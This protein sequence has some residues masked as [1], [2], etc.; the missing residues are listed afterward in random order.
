MERIIQKLDNLDDENIYDNWSIKEI[1]QLLEI[2]HI[3]SRKECEIYDLIY[4]CHG[5][6]SWEDIF[7][8]YNAIYLEDKAY[9]VEAALDCINQTNEEHNVENNNKN[10]DKT[11]NE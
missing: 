4:R 6:D 7:R 9:G 11:K 8:D 10:D 2:Y 1:K 5:C 3:I